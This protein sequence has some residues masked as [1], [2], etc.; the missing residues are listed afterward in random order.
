MTNKIALL[1]KTPKT[2]LDSHSKFTAFFEDLHKFFEDEKK[3]K[4]EDKII[5]LELILKENYF[6]YRIVLSPQIASVVKALLFSYFQE[7]EI[8]E[9]AIEDPIDPQ[10]TVASELKLKYSNYFPILTHFNPESD[11]YIVLS[12]ILSK[13]NRFHDQLMI[14]IVI[15]PNPDPVLSKLWR[16]N[17]SFL[18]A[19]KHKMRM[20]AE[21]PFVTR[22]NMDYS[23]AMNTKFGAHH[24]F[25]NVRLIATGES[26]ANAK[27]NVDLI[28]KAM[29]RFDNGDFNK[30]RKSKS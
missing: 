23:A 16:Q 18:S 30:I 25:A 17:F 4:A 3:L 28:T 1:I 20:F 29:E 8:I 12:A 10:K 15:S 22:G 19:Y 21:K 13:L 7:A 14:Q 2:V 26:K 6:H 24:F 11:P 5:S 9:A 27:S